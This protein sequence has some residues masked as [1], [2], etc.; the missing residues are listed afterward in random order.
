VRLAK[1][2]IFCLVTVMLHAS[3]DPFVGVWKLDSRKSKF[4]IGDPSF[5]FAAIQIEATGNGLKSTASAASGE[6]IASD[7]TFTCSLDGNP[8]PVVAAMPMRGSSAIDTVSLTRVD[9]HTIAAKGM[10][11]GKPIYTDRRVVSGDGNTM[12]VK[13]QGTTPEG[14]DYRSTIVLVRTR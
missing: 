3:A 7:F 4:T 11:G 13:R 12:T 6:G 5:I 10:R 9:D 1:L 14:R 2:S 8:C